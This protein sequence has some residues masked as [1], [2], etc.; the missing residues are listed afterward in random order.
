MYSVGFPID[1]WMRCPNAPKAFYVATTSTGLMI[2]AILW[3]PAER[4]NKKAEDDSKQKR[5]G[6]V[7]R[8]D[9]N[10]DGG[11]FTQLFEVSKID[12]RS[13]EISVH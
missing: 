13:D 2:V 9:F 4:A 12:V 7:G 11:K 10:E 6:K 1:A 3:L 8:F 5:P